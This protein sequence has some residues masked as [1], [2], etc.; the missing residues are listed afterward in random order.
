MVNTIFACTF[1]NCTEQ[2]A[3]QL[4][5]NQKI[6]ALW[7]KRRWH[8]AS[9]KSRNHVSSRGLKN[10]QMACKRHCNNFPRV[11][12][13]VC[14]SHLK[15][16]TPAEECLTQVWTDS[17]ACCCGKV[18]VFCIYAQRQTFDRWVANCPACGEEH[19]CQS[20]RTPAR[21]SFPPLCTLCVY[22]SLQPPVTPY[23]C[24]SDLIDI[25][26]IVLWMY[27]FPLAVT[28]KACTNTCS[29]L[30]LRRSRRELWF[31]IWKLPRA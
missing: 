11:C 27:V 20:D 24:F 1:T 5:L 15:A 16:G 10:E 4:I 13:C 6:K 23:S 12:V 28:V 2:F 19:T 14:T 7:E 3:Y 29:P 26:A 18:H 31:K 17:I 25:S 30:I 8:P 9:L 21:T 22:G